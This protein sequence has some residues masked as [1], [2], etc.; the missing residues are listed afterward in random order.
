M[1]GKKKKKIQ[2]QEETFHFTSHSSHPEDKPDFQSIILSIEA[3]NLLPLLEEVNLHVTQGLL[4]LCNFFLAL[5]HFPLQFV[6]GGGEILVIKRQQ[7]QRC[8][9]LLMA[10]TCLRTLSIFGKNIL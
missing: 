8:D 10:M 3:Q 4:Q 5:A 9:T 1:P 2:I 6:L 7:V